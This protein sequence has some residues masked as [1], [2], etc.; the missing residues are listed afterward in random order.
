M[1]SHHNFEFHLHHQMSAFGSFAA[2]K[3]T[4]KNKGTLNSPSHRPPSPIEPIEPSW[5]LNIRRSCLVV[6]LNFRLLVPSNSQGF[7][8]GAKCSFQKGKGP[9]DL[10]NETLEK[11]KPWN[12]KEISLWKKIGMITKLVNFYPLRISGKFDFRMEATMIKGFFYG[13]N[14]WKHQ[15]VEAKSIVQ[16]PSVL[17]RLSPR[18][19]R[20]EKKQVSS[21]WPAEI[22]K[23]LWSLRHGMKLLECWHHGF[24]I[25]R[26]P[27]LWVL[28]DLEPIVF[29]HCKHSCQSQPVWGIDRIAQNHCH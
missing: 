21:I 19:I 17:G 5:G 29:P 4:T 23:T 6:S 1:K 10:W 13:K 8:M 9:R 11:S 3:K 27:N 14:R 2:Q 15:R 26:P 16:Q 22:S 25:H 7:E 28:L 24:L 12:N 20:M 18:H